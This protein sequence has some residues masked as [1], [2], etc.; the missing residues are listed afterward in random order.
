MMNTCAVDGCD[1]ATRSPGS[2]LCAA[3]YFRKWRYGYTGSPAVSDRRPKS[4]SISDCDGTVEGLGYCSKHYARVK[5]HGDPNYVT[6]PSEYG[7]GDAVLYSAAHCRLR[8]IR[9]SASKYRCQHCNGEAKDWALDHERLGL[10]PTQ[11]RMYT[12]NLDD[13][14]PLCR[15]CHGRY[16]SPSRNRNEIVSQS[17][18]K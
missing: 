14:I 5:T 15:P 6:P 4:C 10:D 9:G 3:H 13:Y 8:R 1:R 17:T 7:S 18:A 16:D 2:S 12:T 11:R